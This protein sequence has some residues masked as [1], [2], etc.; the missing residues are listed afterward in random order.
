MRVK[1]SKHPLQAK[2]ESSDSSEANIVHS[3][4]YLGQPRC[5]DSVCHK[6]TR[7]TQQM[8]SNSQDQMKAMHSVLQVLLD[9]SLG[10]ICSTP[11]SIA[12]DSAEQPKQSEPPGLAW[13]PSLK[14][15]CEVDIQKYTVLL[16]FPGFCECVVSQTQCEP[17]SAHPNRF[18]QL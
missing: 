12:Q 15:Q 3:C 2:Q 16:V 5:V 10:F 1:T 4:L 11:P 18:Y 14:T 7:E 8:F 9:P 6:K 13:K 17:C